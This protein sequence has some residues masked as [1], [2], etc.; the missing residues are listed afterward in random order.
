LGDAGRGCDHLA[1]YLLKVYL[2]EKGMIPNFLAAC[3][4]E[5]LLRLHTVGSTLNL[6]RPL[7]SDFISAEIFLGRETQVFSSFFSTIYTWFLE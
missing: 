6:R 7:S 3:C 5:S 1:Q 2:L 4:S